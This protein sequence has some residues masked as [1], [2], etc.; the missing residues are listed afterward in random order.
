MLKK[1]SKLDTAQHHPTKPGPVIKLCATLR[2][3]GNRRWY[4]V[5]KRH[6]QQQ[7]IYYQE[8]E[9]NCVDMTLVPL[10]RAR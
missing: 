10:Y 8:P 2:G 4:L 9:L 3:P 1:S 5:F 7:Y 6:S